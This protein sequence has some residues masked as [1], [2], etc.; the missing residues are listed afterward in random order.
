MIENKRV[1]AVQI[2]NGNEGQRKKGEEASI[3]VGCGGA[4]HYNPIHT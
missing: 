2:A 1:A 3:C 4:L